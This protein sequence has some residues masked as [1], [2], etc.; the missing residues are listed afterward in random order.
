MIKNF[1]DR[2]NGRALHIPVWSANGQQYR[3]CSVHEITNHKDYWQGQIVT[4]YIPSA[5]SVP[6][7]IDV[8]LMKY[9]TQ[10]EWDVQVTY[11]DEQGR[12]P[13]SRTVMVLPHHLKS[14]DDFGQL[15]ADI[16]D[17]TDINYFN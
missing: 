11:T 5:F 2:I 9:D 16:I 10:M 7:D 4:Q 13:A 12:S 3:V 17:K 6:Y 14:P 8:T 15:I 1:K